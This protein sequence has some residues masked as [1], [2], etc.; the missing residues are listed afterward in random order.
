MRKKIVI[1]KEDFIHEIKFFK[2]KKRQKL[3]E[4]LNNQETLK[5][6]LSNHIIHDYLTRDS[7]QICFEEDHPKLYDRSNKNEDNTDHYEL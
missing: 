3:K 7:H 4:L 1:P 2:E 6:F 5:E